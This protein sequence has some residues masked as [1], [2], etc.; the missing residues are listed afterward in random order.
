MSLKLMILVDTPLEAIQAQEAG[1][2]RIFF[3][4]EYIGKAERQAGIN[5]VKSHN[6]ITMIPQIREVVTSSDLLVRTNP[7]PLP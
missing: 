6:E 1:I 2:D 7:I 5:S 4:L 3:D